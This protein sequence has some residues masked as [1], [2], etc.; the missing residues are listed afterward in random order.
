MVRVVCTIYPDGDNNCNDVGKVIEFHAET[1]DVVYNKSRTY[2]ALGNK[3]FEGIIEGLQQEYML[4][5]N[6]AEKSQ[7][8]EKACNACHKESLR[9]LQTIELEPNK[10]RKKI[11]DALAILETSQKRRQKSTIPELSNGIMLLAQAAESQAN[12]ATEKDMASETGDTSFCQEIGCTDVARFR[13][14]I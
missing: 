10:K 7:V 9:F 13:D 2:T 14:Q 11:R 8:V 3:I 6:S 5:G 1:F 4:A 12:A